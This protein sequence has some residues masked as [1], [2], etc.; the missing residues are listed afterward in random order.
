MFLSEEDARKKVCKLIAMDLM[1]SRPPRPMHAP[2][3][4]ISSECM[5]YWK[6]SNA[7][8]TMGYCSL[9]GKPEF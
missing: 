9:A 1:Y 5:T 4:C 6:W 3:Y 7:E 2:M 8:H